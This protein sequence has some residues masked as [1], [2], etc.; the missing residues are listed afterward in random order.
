MLTGIISVN[1]SLS[2]AC[3]ADCIFCPSNRGIRI[4]QKNMS[5]GVAQKVI[6]EMATESYKKKYRT[7]RMHIGEN[8]DCFIN[9]SAIGIIRYIKDKLPDLSVRVF[10]DAQFFT[11]DKIEIVMRE[12]LL[13]FVGINIDGG[14]T[15]SFFNV[16]RLSSRYVSEFI[17]TFIR[18]RE[19]YGAQTILSVEALTMRHYIDSVRAHLGRNPQ[20]IKDTQLLDAVDDFD[21]IRATILPLLRAGDYFGRSWPIFWAERDLVDLNSLQYDKYECP[22][23]ERVCTEA[24]IAPDGTWYACCR[25]SNNELVLGNVTTTSLDEIAQGGA[26]KEL[27]R[28]LLERQFGKIGGP[29]ATVNCCQIG[30][31]EPLQ[32]KHAVREDE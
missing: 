21:R 15:Q 17:P 2:S 19:Q 30:I 12:S 11:P 3:G 26:R 22:L 18:L 31:L 13:D 28:R 16:K 32:S 10:T 23:I 6:D 7:V 27:I 9:K 24:F 14:T 1:L 29:C 8:G 5:F 4:P 25:D 20:R